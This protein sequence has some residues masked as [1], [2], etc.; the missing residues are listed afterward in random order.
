MK[1]RSVGKL[2]GKITL[3]TGGNNGIGL[4]TAKEF[5]SEGVRVHH[6]TA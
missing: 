4:A 3:V 5:V 1:E 2:E 6:W